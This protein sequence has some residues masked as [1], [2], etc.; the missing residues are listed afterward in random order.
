[1]SKC[2]IE[3]LLKFAKKKKKKKAICPNLRKM[4]SVDRINKSWNMKPGQDSYLKIT[5][6]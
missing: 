6:G 5:R 2:L 4:N 3:A 1:M